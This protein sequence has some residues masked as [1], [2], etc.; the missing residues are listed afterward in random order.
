[1][2]E[3][4][5]APTPSPAELKELKDIDETFPDRLIKMAEKEQRFRHFSTFFGQSGLIF[6][7]LGGYIIAG[8]I[9]IQSQVVG[10]AIAIS[11]SYIAY[12]FKNKNP[13]PPKNLKNSQ[14]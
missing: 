3:T 10:I 9:G 2:T 4:R 12:V 14:T 11:I 5:H 8:I 6:L 7:V 1:M 13:K